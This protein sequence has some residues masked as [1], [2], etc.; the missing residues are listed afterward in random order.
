MHNANLQNKTYLGIRIYIN[1]E[2]NIMNFPTDFTLVTRAGKRPSPLQGALVLA[3]AS[4]LGSSKSFWLILAKSINF[5][6]L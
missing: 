2:P 6:W 5:G 3:S 4:T 1:A